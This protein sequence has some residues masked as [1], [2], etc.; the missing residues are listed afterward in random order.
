MLGV[1][2]RAVVVGLRTESGPRVVSL[3]ARGAAAVPNGVRLAGALIFLGCG[4]AQLPRSAPAGCESVTSRFALSGRGARGCRW[5][6]RTGPGVAMLATAAAAA[7]R[8]V[9]SGAIS[10]LDDALTRP[11]DGDHDLAGA[12]DGLVGLGRG[13]TP[14]GDDVLA[15]AL[16]GLHAVGLSRGGPDHRRTGSAAD[17]RTDHAGVRGSA[18]AGRRRPCVPGGAGGAAGDPSIRLG[19]HGGRNRAVPV[20]RSRRRST[21]CWRSGIPVEPTWRADWQSD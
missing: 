12:V 10:R 4:R 19:K 1:F 6:G 11:A 21:G 16:T 17:H 20:H 8:G 9:P 5:C 15:G 3:L 2:S 14:G 18:A 7:E 13:L